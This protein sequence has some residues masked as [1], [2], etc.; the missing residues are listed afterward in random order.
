MG[1]T[2]KTLGDGDITR[3]ALAILHN[4]LVFCKTINRQY[5]DRFT[6]SGALNGGQLLIRE[7]NQFEVATSA[8]LD[9]QDV[10][11]STQTLTVATRRGVHVNFSTEELT[12]SMDDFSE[13]ILEPAMSR[14]AA[15][16]DKVVVTDCYKYVY[17]HVLGTAAGPTVLADV[18]SARSLISKGLA[19]EDNRTLMAESL[20]MNAIVNE[21]KALFHPAS[22]IEMQWN[23]GYVGRAHSFKFYETE[24]VPN[25]TTGSR[26][27]TTPVCNTSTGITSGT[28]TITTTGYDSGATLT[29]GDVFTIADVYAVNLETKQRYPHLQQFVVTTAK[30]LDGTDVIAVSPTPITSGAKQNVELVSA[31]ASKAII[32][33]TAG[34]S[35]AAST[36]YINNMAYHRDAFTLVTADL[37]MP[38]GT[39][40]AHRAVYDGISLRLVRDYDVVNDKLPCR[41]DVLFGWKTLRPEWACRLSAD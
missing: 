26:D 21:A 38:K 22:E 18:Q 6:K 19:P 7:P 11:E 35:G 23:K 29:Q 1:N 3:K 31:G 37:I 12:L 14:L 16:L 10:T 17:N 34:G 9:T 5:D 32:N 30:A 27:D 25:H 15:E 33:V 36:T 8:T 2:I 39:D 28:A 40:M 20:S 41:L 13:R 4:K 24:T